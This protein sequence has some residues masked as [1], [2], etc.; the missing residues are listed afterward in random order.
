[1]FYNVFYAKAK[2]LLNPGKS[3]YG[4]TKSGVNPHFCGREPSIPNPS[5]NFGSNYGKE[6]L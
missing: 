4:G 1:M 2:N 5:A 3:G 6:F